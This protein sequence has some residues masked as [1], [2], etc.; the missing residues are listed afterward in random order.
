MD[1]RII[2]GCPRHVGQREHAAHRGRNPVASGF[3][4]FATMVGTKQETLT[5]IDSLGRE[6]TNRKDT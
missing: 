6:E 3:K 5:N 4:L 2:P 1:A